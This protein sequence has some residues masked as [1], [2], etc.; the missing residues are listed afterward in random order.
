[1]L[2]SPQEPDPNGGK[3]SAPKVTA[4][5]VLKLEGLCRFLMISL[6]TKKTK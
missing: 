5:T 1:M 2:H 3:A 6:V 4:K